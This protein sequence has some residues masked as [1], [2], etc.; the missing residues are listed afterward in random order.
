[1]PQQPP[2]H[3]GPSPHVPQSRRCRLET[4]ATRA[5][6]CAA[7]SADQA[8]PNRAWS[9]GPSEHLGLLFLDVMVDAVT[10]NGKPG[11]VEVVT[12]L[13]GLE[14]RDQILGTRV[15]NRGLVHQ[16]GILDRLPRRRIEDLLLDPGVY[17]QVGAGLAND[18]RLAAL[19]LAVLDFLEILEC[20][21]HFLVIGDQHCNRIH[22]SGRLACCH[23]ISPRLV[24]Q[25]NDDAFRR[26]T[27]AGR[28]ADNS[29]ARSERRFIRRRWCTR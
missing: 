27:A 23:F 9:C 12:R 16:I 24:F 3:A 18:V 14:L 28:H 26:R 15:L 19:A 1:M 4:R 22:F 17:R 7:P 6:P 21:L 29:K 2:R 8:R 11:V 20:F 13:H 5:P 25:L 10:Q